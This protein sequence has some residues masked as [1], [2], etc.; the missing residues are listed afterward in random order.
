MVVINRLLIVLSVVFLSFSGVVLAQSDSCTVDLLVNNQQGWIIDS[1]AQ[2]FWQ[3]GT[4]INA[5]VNVETNEYQVN[6]HKSTTDAITI[7]GVDFDRLVTGNIQIFNGGASILNEPIVNDDVIAFDF[8]LPASGDIRIVV[9]SPDFFAITVLTLCVETPTPTMTITASQTPT[10][11]ATASAT[12]TLTPVV[13]ASPTTIA[14][15]PAPFTPALANVSVLSFNGALP[16]DQMVDGI[17]VVGNA[18]QA[19]SGGNSWFQIEA[20]ANSEICGIIAYGSNHD[21]NRMTGVTNPNTSQTLQSGGATFDLSSPQAV[22]VIFNI[23]GTTA[24]V[25]VTRNSGQ[26]PFINEVLVC[27]RSLFTPTPSP[28]VTP[29]STVPCSSGPTP[30]PGAGTA[31]VVPSA[32][33]GAGTATVTPLSPCP[34]A[35]STATGTASPTPAPA[36]STGTAS[37]SP[38]PGSATGTASPV[39]PPGGTLPSP[40]GGTPGGPGV[41][42][43]PGGG[44]TFPG[45]EW[46]DPFGDAVSPCT[47]VP[48]VSFLSTNYQCGAYVFPAWPG[49][50]IQV[51]VYFSYLVQTLIALWGAATC[52][53]GS[54]FNYTLGFY[55]FVFVTYHWLSYLWC[56]M[57]ELLRLLGLFLSR[58]WNMVTGLLLAVTEIGVAPSDF[59]GVSVETITDTFVNLLSNTYVRAIFDIILAV[60]SLGMWFRIAKNFV[61]ASSDE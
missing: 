46:P 28:T 5:V 48:S 47:V 44:V 3:L 6:T 49:F 27:E 9:T 35:T 17:I 60:I 22:T 20:T 30:T 10:S 33:P 31:T 53:F 32:T 37:P 45:L 38:A 29:T 21:S 40:G 25:A 59:M 41:V 61:G 43:T 14:S 2:G 55:N 1:L 24:R 57:S 8:I 36:T 13:T 39:P 15:C 50:T 18:W 23:C 52:F 54:T 51:W 4:G 26:A 34:T 58:I 56:M 7:I 19:A 12:P 42:P 16:K 11:T